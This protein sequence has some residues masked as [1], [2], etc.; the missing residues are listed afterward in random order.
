MPTLA[1]LETRVAELEREV[2]Q[3]RTKSPEALDDRK[4]FEKL[5]K[6]DAADSDEFQLAMKYGREI[7]N[8]LPDA[9]EGE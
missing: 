6:I 5:P 4:W 1:E 7:C 2:S 8:V 9:A 3:L